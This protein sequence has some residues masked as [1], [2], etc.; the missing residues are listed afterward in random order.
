M[1]ATAHQP[2]LDHSRQEAREIG[3]PKYGR[4]EQIADR[5]IHVIG[6][7][8]SV[9][10]FA[11]LITVALAQDSFPLLIS[12]ALYGTGL[13]AMLGCSA[14]YNMTH[15]AS[16]KEVLRRLDHAAIFIMIAGSYTPFALVKI[17]GAWGVGL[18]GYVWIIAAGGVLMKLLDPRRLE[19][20]SIGLY[21]LLGWVGVVALNPLLS[22]LPL[23][24]IAL[25]GTGGLLYSV[26]VLFHLWGR[27]VYQNA[28]WHAFVLAGAACH[29]AAV[30]RYVAL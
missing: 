6:V 4:D 30:L 29:Y 26:G 21:L 2:E 18:F 17:G 22:A 3:F 5:C 10:G 16:R 19:R 7:T 24:A 25:L 15:H 12:L 27:L 9:I 1:S 23:P 11:V 8:G 14:L 20:L 28:I 13:V